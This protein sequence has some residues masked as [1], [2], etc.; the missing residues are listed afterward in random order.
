M[1]KNQEGF[2]NLVLVG[3]VVILVAVGA[4]FTLSKKSG[5]IVEPQIPIKN[6][7]T[8]TDKT[9][10]WKTYTNNEYGF[11]F[12][13]P[14]T[15]QITEE[16]DQ[17]NFDLRPE[18]PNNE[19]FNWFS[20]HLADKRDRQIFNFSVSINHPGLGFGGT[21]TVS[22][23]TV[24]IDGVNA[25]K[26]IF[27]EIGGEYKGEKMVLYTFNKSGNGYMVLG[28]GTYE[29]ADTILSTFKFTK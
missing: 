3:A 19:L 20:L 23:T 18:D 7:Q 17:R 21:E 1:K 13:Y 11:E 24:T 14:D 9:A 15:L 27:Q 6:T 29:L 2:A 4:Y 8:S 12:K 22:K 10:N 25:N 16:S 26:E 5:P 28:T